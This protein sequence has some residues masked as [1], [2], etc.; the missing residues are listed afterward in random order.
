M[1]K[2]K[3]LATLASLCYILGIAAIL[4]IQ[5][6]EKNDRGN[7]ADELKDISNYYSKN[8]TTANLNPFSALTPDWNNIYVHED[9]QEVIYEIELQNPKKV[10]ESDHQLK[11]N[12]AVN[13]SGNIIRLLIFKNKQDNVIKGGCYM[14]ISSNDDIAVINIKYKHPDNFSGKISYYNLNGSFSNGWMYSKGEVTKRIS[15]SSREAYMLN[16]KCPDLVGNAG[17]INNTKGEKIM[18]KQAVACYPGVPQFIYAT[19]CAG[20]DDSG[21]VVCTTKLT[22]V[23]YTEF[24]EGGGNDNNDGGYTP[25][26]GGG[27]TYIVDCNGDRNGKAYDSDCGCIGGNTG[28]TECPK[29]I[30]DSIN[31]PCIKEQLSLA[32]SAKTTIRNMLND[33]FGT[34]NFNDRDIV[35]YDITTLADT[36]AGTTHGNSAYSFIINLNENTLP[37]RSKEY[38]LSTIYHEILH[39][40]M[41]TQIGKDASGNYL[42]SNQHQTM[43]DRYV[44]LMTG[45]LKIAFPNLSDRDAWALSW[46]GLEDTPFYK[47]KL[48]EIERVEIQN[49]MTTHRKNTAANLRHG[50]YCN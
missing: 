33:E 12:E 38:I 17:K 41:D 8:V 1:K 11:S 34:A 28:I 31:N 10:V 42:I 14:S 45:A 47:T 24:C 21:E 4:L 40:Y 18:L 25:P 44:F 39:A 36:V 49:L 32:Q 7:L 5:G 15:L 23:I 50:T 16:N 29:E 3:L 48:S 30:K 43:A 20:D 22:A 2:T 27:T 26:G 46:G 35:F 9:G 13:F 19:V 6:C 37:Q